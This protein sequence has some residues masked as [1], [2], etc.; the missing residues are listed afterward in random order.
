MPKRRLSGWKNEAIPVHLRSNIFLA[1]I[2]GH[3]SSVPTISLSE[4]LLKRSIWN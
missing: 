3:N 1:Q 2:L 4:A